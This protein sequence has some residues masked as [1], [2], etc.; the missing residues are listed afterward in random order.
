MYL[1]GNNPNM[2]LKGYLFRPDGLIFDLED[3]VS[4]NQKDAARILV[5]NVLSSQSFGDCEVSV[6]INALDTEF[7]R[8]DLCAVGAA[9]AINRRVNGIRM[10]KAES[11]ESVIA[12]D[13][14]L[15]ELE[16]KNSLPQGHFKIFCLL[17][18]ANAVW[19]AYD[20][21]TASRRVTGLTP[22]GEDLAADLRTTRSREESELDWIRKMILVAGR[23]A[24]VDV[25]DA[26]YPLIHDL[27]GLKKQTEG[28][29][30]LGFDGKSVLHPSQIQVIHDVFTPSATDIEKSL[31]IVRAAA[32]ATKNGQGAV[33]VDG[34]L[35]DV[36]VIKRAMYLLTLAG[37]DAEEAVL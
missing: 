23:A 3:A 8:D 22:G 35:V 7:W 16:D 34:R 29:R 32:E 18:S 26:A 1:P 28:I 11:K 5:R 21:A 17:E 33:A 14:T 37:L 15:S 10:P 6:R 20:I 36:P 13:D 12:L 9:A 25:L 27:E 24:G 30:Q 2:L 31:R 4:A 19:K